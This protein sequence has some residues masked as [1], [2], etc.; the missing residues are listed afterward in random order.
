LGAAGREFTCS[1]CPILAF[2]AAIVA[3]LSAMAL[4]ILA[5]ICKA[6]SR[7]VGV[8]KESGDEEVV[9]ESLGIAGKAEALRW[10]FGSE[11]EGVEEVVEESLGIAGKAEALRWPFG[12]EEEGVEEVVEESLG[13]AGKAEALRWPFGSEEEGVEEEVEISL[14]IAGK[15]EALRW[16]FGSEEEVE[17]EGG[18]L[19]DMSDLWRFAEPSSSDAFRLRVFVISA[20][21]IM[22]LA[23][24]SRSHRQILMITYRSWGIRDD[25]NDLLRKGQRSAGISRSSGD[26]STVFATGA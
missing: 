2:K 12:S 3:S 19:S 17:E 10:P 4:F 7:V 9:E 6:S 5:M 23:G 11:E 25:G 8:G 20:N 16:P 15:A 13:I 14:G 24:C 1:S 21:G 26:V 18:C 22:M